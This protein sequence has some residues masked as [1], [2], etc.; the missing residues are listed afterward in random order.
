MGSPLKKMWD[1]R[2]NEH[3]WG[4]IVINDDTCANND[5]FRTDLSEIQIHNYEYN[6]HCNHSLKCL[7]FWHNVKSF[8]EKKHLQTIKDVHVELRILILSHRIYKYTCLQEALFI[9]N[10][11]NKNVENYFV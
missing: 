6:E 5:V 3:D 9:S 10:A 1:G 8:I 2:R 11:F 7:W 4:L